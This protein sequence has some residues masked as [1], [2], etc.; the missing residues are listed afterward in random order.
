MTACQAPVDDKGGSP[1]GGAGG[2]NVMATGGGS[3]GAVPPATPLAPPSGPCAAIDPQALGKQKDWGA[4]LSLVADVNTGIINTSGTQIDVDLLLSLGDG[5]KTVT[6]QV[7]EISPLNLNGTT[8]TVSPAALA[9][10]VVSVGLTQT[11]ENGCTIIRQNQP[12]QAVL[13]A[14]LSRPT[15]AL[16]TDS[17]L[18]GGALTDCA[19]APTPPSGGCVCDGDHDGFPGVSLDVMN[20]PF[21]PNIDKFYAVFRA[22]VQLVGKLVSNNQINGS[23]DANFDQ[24]VLGCHDRTGNCGIGGLLGGLNLKVTPSTAKPSKFVAMPVGAGNVSCAAVKQ[25]PFPKEQ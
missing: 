8:V 21:F 17:M 11:Q 23:V 24:R 3:P 12:Y 25:L 20:L 7:C 4:R 10:S 9:G 22:Q 16:P 18:C 1:T 14:K 2:H 19:S 13:G 5:G 6:F 15:D